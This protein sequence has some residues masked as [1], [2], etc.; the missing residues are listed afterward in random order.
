MTRYD[1]LRAELEVSRKSWEDLL[2][3]KGI[4]VPGNREETR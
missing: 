1:S 4:P 2:K 3:W